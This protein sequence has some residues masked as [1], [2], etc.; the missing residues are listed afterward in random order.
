MISNAI[1]NRLKEIQEGM[2]KLSDAEVRDILEKG[3]TQAREIAS[4]N[5]TKVK[6]ILN[7]YHW[8][9]LFLDSSHLSIILRDIIR[10]I[11]LIET[12]FFIYFI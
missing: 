7:L 6:Q 2:E 10:Q 5:L 4:E 8:N 9:K 12:V 1:S 11:I 3:A